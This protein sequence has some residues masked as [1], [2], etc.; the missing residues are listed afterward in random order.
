MVVWR[1]VLRLSAKLLPIEDDMIERKCQCCGVKFTARK[2][3]VARGWGLF[4][5][6][7]CKAIKQEART[8]QYAS[9]ARDDRTEFERDMDGVEVGWEAHK[10]VY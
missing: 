5:S 9:L 4:C 8:G 3:D 2:A 10:D 1:M 7:R 6:K